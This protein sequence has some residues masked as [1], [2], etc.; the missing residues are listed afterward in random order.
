M[1]YDSVYAATGASCTASFMRGAF[2]FAIPTASFAARAISSTV[3][4]WEPEN[5]HAPPARTRIPKPNVSESET[6]GTWLSLP[7]AGSVCERRVTTWLR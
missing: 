7:V 5:P 1:A 4:A 3:T 2:A 6:A